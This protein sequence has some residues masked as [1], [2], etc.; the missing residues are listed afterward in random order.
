MILLFAHHLEP[1][2]L[3]VFFM[4]FAAGFAL[5]WQGVG[6]FLGRSRDVLS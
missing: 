1:Q 3:P 6:Q 5:G 2:H 4:L